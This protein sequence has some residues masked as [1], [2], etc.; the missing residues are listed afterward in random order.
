MRVAV[1]TAIVILLLPAAELLAFLLVAWVIGFFPAIGLMLLTSLAGIFALRRLSGGQLA[2]FR[3][4]L[5]ER[6]VGEA[7]VQ[8]GGPLVA[9]G[10][11]LL[12]LP[13]FI[14]DLAGLGLLVPPLRRR[15]GAALGRA[16][17][18]RARPG[19]PLVIDLA[20]SEWRALPDRKPRR[21]RRR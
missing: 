15:F 1:R 21:L 10:G 3:R 17:A 5:R 6:Q 8:G 9:L 11:I 14:T 4:V 16:L 13:G 19:E 12:V 7:A 2:Q 20:R 18:P